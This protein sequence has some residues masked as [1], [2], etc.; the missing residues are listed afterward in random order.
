MATEG[1]H[2]EPSPEPR[3]VLPVLSYATPVSRRR[4]GR[5][6]RRRIV[7]A[8]AAD[9]V[10]FTE[11]PTDV[12]WAIGAMVFSALPV[13]ALLLNTLHIINHWR[14]WSDPHYATQ[15]ALLLVLMLAEAGALAGV[16]H[17]IVQRTV[18]SVQAGTLVLKRR[19]LF[20]SSQRQWSADEIGNIQAWPIKQPEMGQEQLCA[21]HIHPRQGLTVEVFR[22][23]G[24]G[25]LTWVVEV[26]S[27]ALKTS[28]G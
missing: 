24:Q 17:H 11:V 16:I 4:A 9:G 13:T 18:L 2:I 21:V 7:Y 23:Y 14:R 12:A 19:G 22:D 1:P 15:L 3:Q 25:E 6:L 8:A 20:G 10:A 28:P 5:P 27:K 26:L